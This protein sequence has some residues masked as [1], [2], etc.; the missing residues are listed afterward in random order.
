M[1]HCFLMPL[2]RFEGLTA[3][4]KRLDFSKKWWYIKIVFLSVCF[5]LT[6][7]VPAERHFFISKS[8]HRCR[9]HYRNR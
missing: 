1:P 8:P 6:I 2:C 5:G 3:S 9:S 7:E 4:D